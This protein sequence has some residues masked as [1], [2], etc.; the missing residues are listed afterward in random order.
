MARNVQVVMTEDLE[1]VGNS[2]EVVRV[3]PG[4]A[5]NFLIPRGLA[6]MA[7]KRNIARVEHDQRVAAARASKLRSAAEA[8]GEK[9]SALDITIEVTAGEEEKLYGSVTSRDIADAL[10]SHDVEID[11]RKI[12]LEPIKALGSHPIRIDLGGGVSVTMEVKVVAKS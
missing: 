9:I 4:F 6:T 8:L 1:N 11:R 2:G 3:R 5:R 10:A 12:E 7:S